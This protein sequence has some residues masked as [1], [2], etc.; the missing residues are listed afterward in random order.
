MS[1]AVAGTVLGL[2]GNFGTQ[3]VK[4]ST[5]LCLVN[6]VSLLRD[7]SLED[8]MTLLPQFPNSD[9]EKWSKYCFFE[10]PGNTS[11]GY[12]WRILH[13]IQNS[14]RVPKIDIDEPFKYYV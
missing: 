13:Q 5:S 10:K 6:H 12:K 4:A 11:F 9:L 3:E 1:L 8:S 7:T 14:V 2:W